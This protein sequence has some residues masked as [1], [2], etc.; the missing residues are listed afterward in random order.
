MV[1]LSLDKVAFLKWHVISNDKEV[2]LIKSIIAQSQSTWYTN[3][4]K[5][6]APASNSVLNRSILIM[7]E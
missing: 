4:I 6:S 3:D 2:F 7:V 5:M 1:H